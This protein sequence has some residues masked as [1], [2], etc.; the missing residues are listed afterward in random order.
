MLSGYQASAR[1]ALRG[2]GVGAANHVAEVVE[3]EAAALVIALQYTQPRNGV[4][5]GTGERSA[6]YQYPNY[7]LAKLPHIPF[8]TAPGEPA[9]CHE[10]EDWQY[11][12]VLKGKTLTVI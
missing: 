7:S 11:L 2:L 4:G 12:L 9:V 10:K 6:H 3:P 8:L 1:I 5:L